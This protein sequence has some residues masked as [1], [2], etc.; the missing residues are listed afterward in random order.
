MKENAM[1]MTNTVVLNF[2]GTVGKSTI[3]KHLIC[4]MLN[5]AEWIQIE[6]INNSAVGADQEMSAR[7]FRGL[8]EK[9]AIP[10]GNRV[11]NIG[12]S[13]V[14]SVL[15]Q[16]SQMDGVQEDIDWWV[17]PTDERTKVIAD[18][19]N[20]VAHLINELNVD[21]SRIVVLANNVEFPDDMDKQFKSIIDAQ[22]IA[23]FHFPL[24]PILKSDLFD[25][26][27]DDGATIIQVANST[28][29]IDEQIIS[30]QEPDKL[31]A[32]GRKKVQR[33]MAKVVSRNL[34]AV[35]KST[36]MSENSSATA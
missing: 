26:L 21:P 36:P 5:N 34:A 18:T 15:K 24:V 13:N 32:L 22:S 31:A 11:I 23:G 33:R 9:L 20:T 8:A 2:A 16:M 10:G 25:T 6:S 35:W 27:K 17:V 19:L 30:E 3:T 12:G 29:N 7:Q 14:E 4:P 1:K 28:D